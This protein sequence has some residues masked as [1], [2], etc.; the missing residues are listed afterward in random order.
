MPSAALESVFFL[1]GL[2]CDRAVWEHQ[3]QGISDLALPT[4]V[5]W[6][7][8]DSLPAMAETVLRGAPERFAVAG[9]SMGGRVALEV[10]RAAPQRLARIALLDTGFQERARDA[11]GDEEERGRLAL[12]SLAR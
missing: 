6:D 9:H 4:C 2:V 8:E 1:P 7:Q 11:A 12:L 3:A 10:Y 5:E